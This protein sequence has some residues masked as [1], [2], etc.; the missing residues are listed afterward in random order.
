MEPTPA[1]RVDKW[2]RSVRLFKTRSLASQACTAG[3][4]QV[5]GQPAKPARLVR[6]GDLIVAFTGIMTRTVKVLAPVER[7]VGAK[8]VPRYLEDLTPPTEYAKLRERIEAP[9]GARLKGTG[10]PTKKDRRILGSFFGLDE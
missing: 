4:V 7:R 6:S 5:N 1:I 3:H 9:A 8:M 2:L 10:R